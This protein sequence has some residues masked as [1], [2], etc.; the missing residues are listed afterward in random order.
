MNIQGIKVGFELSHPRVVSAEF[1]EGSHSLK[2]KSK[3]SGECMVLIY[4]EGHRNTI[5]DTFKVT[6]ATIVEPS[7]SGT[8]EPVML[9]LGSAAKFT[10]IDHQREDVG[11][12]SSDSKVLQIDSLTGNSKAINEGEAQ[13]SLSN[14]I[15]AASAVQVSRITSAT[16]DDQEKDLVINLDDSSDLNVRVKLYLRNSN[17]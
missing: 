3:G 4:L 17:R 15:S 14:E 10:L 12:F 1:E 11:W 5:Y 7:P 16:L 6:V 9:H 13:I 2:L 8:G